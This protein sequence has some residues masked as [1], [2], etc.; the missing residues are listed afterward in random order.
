VAC[1]ILQV[2]K[3]KQMVEQSAYI[4]Y[5]PGAKAN[6][7]PKTVTGRVDVETDAGELKFEAKLEGL[8]ASSN[9]GLHIHYGTTCDTEATVK[10]DAPQDAN[11]GHYY[12]PTSDDAS[13]D[14]WSNVKWTSDADGKATIEVILTKAEL[15]TAPENALGRV[16]I[17]HANN[18]DKVACGIL[19]DEK[20][21]VEQSSASFSYFLGAKPEAMP[22]TV[23]GS[24]EVE[25]DAGELKFEANLEGLEG[26]SSGGPTST[27]ARRV[28]P[29]PP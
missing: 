28:T 11:K 10:G 26:C 2:E 20:P 1:G 5:F 24:V 8:E 25:T 15:N 13:E 19:Q 16:V 4:I 6:A 23:T 14:P 12:V 17:V 22:T 7:M 27:T 21:R 29:R 9:G 3:P 18:G